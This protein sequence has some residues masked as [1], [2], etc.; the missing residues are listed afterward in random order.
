[1]KF[2]NDISST[3]GGKLSSTDEPPSRICFHF[4]R[5]KQKHFKI[6]HH[7]TYLLKS[8]MGTCM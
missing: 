8:S 3:S 1:M 2:H 6:K 5:L 7:M 4:T